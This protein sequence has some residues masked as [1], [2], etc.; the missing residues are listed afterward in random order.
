MSMQT[1]TAHEPRVRVGDGTH[2]Y[3]WIENWVKIPDTASGRANGRTHGIVVTAAGR[4]IVFHQANPA[5]LVFDA[6]GRL[7]FSWGDRFA[8]AHG[9]TLVRE[10]NGEFL[11]LTD[12]HSGEVV[13]TSFAGRTVM[14]L[15]RPD[16]AVYR[17]GNYAPTWVAVHEE[18]L[19]GNGDVWVADGY[20]MNLVHRYDRRGNYVA[21]IDGTEGTA[22]AFACPHGIR[23][24]YRTG[25]PELY[26]ADRGNRR[27][28]VYDPEGRFKRA[29]GSEFLSCPCA[30]TAVGDDLVVPELNA[31]LD[32][33]DRSDR[34][35]CSLGDNTPACEL[36][37]WPDHPKELLS[38]GRFNSPHAVASDAVGN[39][40]V[41]EWI[42]GGRVT[43]LE[44]VSAAAE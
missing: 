6:E 7:L 2:T 37:G 33:L 35:V 32:I 10:G 18:R 25:D 34:L 17:N 13:K 21:S 43:R 42:V 26:I 9:M 20:G 40:Y 14:N 11:W 39:L 27:F 22:G 41:V 28:Q 24:D 23:M 36:P 38:P 1:A 12:E 31:R 15:R 19:G 44:K 30:S 5:V 8:G 3:D 4:V 16:I 29:F